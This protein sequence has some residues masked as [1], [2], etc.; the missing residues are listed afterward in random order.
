MQASAASVIIVSR[1]RPKAL[2]RCLLAVSQLMHSKFEIIVVSDIAGLDAVAELPFAERVKTTHFD[3]PNISMARNLGIEMAAGDIVAFIDDDAVPE[4]SWLSRLT[5]P[6]EDETVAAAG[7]YVRGRNGISFQWRAS[8]VDTAGRRRPLRVEGRKPIV[9]APPECRAVK[10]EGTNCAFRRDVLAKMGGFDPA[11]AFYLDETDVNM[12]LAVAG[13]CTAIVPMAQ[14]HH[15]YFSSQR[16]N[17]ARAPKSL[18]DIGRSTAHFC[19]KYAD[20]IDAKLAWRAEVISQRKRL[21]Q[22][23][24]LGT[25]EPRDVRRLMRSLHEGYAEGAQLGATPLAPIAATDAPF[26]NFGAAPYVHKVLSGRIWQ[27]RRLRLEAKSLTNANVR[28]TL[29]LFSPTALFHRLR[30]TSQGFWEQKGG[31]FGKSGRNQPL[32]QFY[33]FRSRLRDEVSRTE[34]FREKP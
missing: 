14:V 1:A 3:E 5:A 16:R 24:I 34:M 29:F 11:F 28:V 6:F 20:P 2:A 19:R 27:R 25:I 21:I 17:R 22:H 26:R 32:F 33:G 9:F 7:G 15:G 12:R 23:M 8:S 30:F 31:L 4:P 18:F 10:T 13:H